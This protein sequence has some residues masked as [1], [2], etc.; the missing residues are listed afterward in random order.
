[1]G[2]GR[3]HCSRRAAAR[4]EEP[5][6]DDRRRSEI[7]RAKALDTEAVRLY[8]AGRYADALAA[9]RE[10]VAIKERLL[11]PEHAGVGAS[12]TN[13]GAILQAQGALREGASV[14]ARAL[15]ITEATLGAEDEATEKA[16][17]NLASVHHAAGDFATARPLFERALAIAEKVH[18]AEAASTADSLV[19]LGDEIHVDDG[20][21][22]RS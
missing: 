6:P 11:G 7:E 15:A 19:N 8:R 2:L 13:V 18:G 17:T 1:L 21:E 3:V 10:A 4:P 5:A 16:I 12:L 9:A 20:A 14:L 22:K